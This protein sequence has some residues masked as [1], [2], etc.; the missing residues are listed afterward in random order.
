MKKD[1]IASSNIKIQSTPEKVWNVLT[2]PEKIKE[3]LFGTEV[4]TDWEVGSPIIFQR[5]YN[6]QKYLDKGNVIEKKE[7]KLLKYNYWSGFSG[8]EDK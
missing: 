6:G 7:N 2:N 3:Y 4:K 5:E 1:L 8:L